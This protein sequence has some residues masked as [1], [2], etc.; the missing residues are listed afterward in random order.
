MAWLCSVSLII[1][2]CGTTAKFVYPSHPQALISVAATP[3]Y[4]RSVAVLP[5]EEAR[6]DKNSIGGMFTY[7][8]P[9]MPFGAWSYERPDAAR[10]FL[11]VMDFAFDVPE[12]LAKAA[13][14]SLQKSNLFKRVYFSYGGDLEKADYVVS[15]TVHSTRYDGRVFSYGL[16][17]YGPGLSF[18]GLPMGS[19]RNT[20]S[21]ALQM[22]QPNA[23]SSLWQYAFTKERTVIQGIWYRMGH[24]VK[25]YTDLMEEGMNEAIRDLDQKLPAIITQ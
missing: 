23:V 22:R 2:G 8:I 1:A 25:G 18:I 20:L 9:L 3:R 12:D 21:L 14:T 10:M 13:V 4:D 15:G 7:L 19:S 17:V 16:S 5:F 24:D 11:S 6:P